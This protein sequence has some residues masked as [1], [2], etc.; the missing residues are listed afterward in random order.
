MVAVRTPEHPCETLIQWGTY[1]LEEAGRK[2][3]DR[4]RLGRAL[5][6]MA[7]ALAQWPSEDMTRART[8]QEFKNAV[9]LEENRR[10]AALQLRILSMEAVQVTRDQRPDFIP[11][12]S[13]LVRGILD[14][15]P[16][17]LECF[18]AIDLPAARPTLVPVARLNAKVEFV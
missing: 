14:G 16:H 13:D 11:R 6:G 10:G 17:R 12:A 9:R 18:A 8:T 5:V 15:E 7:S 1:F 4:R 2:Q 3:P